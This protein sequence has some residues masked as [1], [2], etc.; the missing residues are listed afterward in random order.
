MAL[1]ARITK[2]RN[3]LEDGENT[4]HM[5]WVMKANLSHQTNGTRAGS[6]RAR[7]AQNEV[8]KKMARTRAVPAVTNPRT[9]VQV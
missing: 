1:V 3:G 7:T 6:L 8:R 5:I 2:R 9:V 4:T